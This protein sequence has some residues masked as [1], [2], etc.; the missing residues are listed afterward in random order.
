MDDGDVPVLLSVNS[1]IG[2]GKIAGWSDFIAS[3]T[4]GKAEEADMKWLKR[5]GVVVA[6]GLLLVSGGV[7]RGETL[8]EAISEIIQS[9][10][11]VKAQS[12]NRF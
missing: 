10:P 3:R 4:A 11:E 7:A 1:F 9:N 12:Y 8:T 6:V 5:G 2:C